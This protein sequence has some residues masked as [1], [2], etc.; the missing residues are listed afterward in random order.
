MLGQI[1]LKSDLKEPVLSL[2]WN[3][4]VSPTDI[5]VTE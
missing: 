2:T 1:R 5:T 3:P 4:S